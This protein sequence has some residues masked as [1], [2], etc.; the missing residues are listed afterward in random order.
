MEVS[1]VTGTAKISATILTKLHNSYRVCARAAVRALRRFVPRPPP[2]HWLRCAP[3]SGRK[4]FRATR[5]V[6]GLLLRLYLAWVTFA[7]ALNFA[8]WQ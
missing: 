1:S 6:A 8:L 5:P 3:S 4:K 7:S 2:P